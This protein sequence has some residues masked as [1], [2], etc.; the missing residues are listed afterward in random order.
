M[1]ESKGQGG[2][3]CRR[4][5]QVDQGAIGQE[6]QRIE[7][8]RLREEQHRLAEES[9]QAEQMRIDEGIRL[10]EERSEEGQRRSRA[11]R[12]REAKRLRK[13]QKRP[14]EERHQ[15]EER[16]RE[17]ERR[18]EEKR[19]ERCHEEEIRKEEW[20]REEEIRKEERRREEEERKERERVAREEREARWRKEAAV[21][22]QYLVFDS[23]LITSAAGLDIRNIVTGF[24][25]CGITIK[26]LPKD[27]KVEEIA[28]IFLQQGIS[29]AD[30][31]ITGVKEIGNF[32]KSVI[33][34]NAEYGQ[35][36]AIGLEG[37]KFRDKPLSFEI[38]DNAIPDAMGATAQSR[39]PFMTVSWR[40]LTNSIVATYMS[41][42]MAQRKVRE[43][44]GQIWRGHCITAAMN[45]C[46]PRG[47]RA[48]VMNSVKITNIPQN[49]I[50]DPEFSGFIG[51]HNVCSLK[52][53]PYDHHL[54]V[55]IHLSQQTGVQLQTY[56]ELPTDHKGEARV[57]V[58]FDDWE[59]VKLAHESIHNK[60]LGSGVMLTPN[61]RAWHPRPLQYSI[62][63]PSRQYSAQKKLWD[64]LLEKAGKEAFVQTREGGR[65]NAVFVRVL[66]DNKKA[67]GALK[68]RVEKLV[69]GEALG[70][71]YWHPSFLFS[72]TSQTFFDRTFEETGAFVRTD[73]KTRTL[74]IYGEAEK[75]GNGR[76]LI[77][78]EVRRLQGLET[79]CIIGCGSIAFFVREGV[80]RLKEL[81]GEEN[82]TL[83]LADRPC[84]ITVK[85][86]QEAI[87]H[88][89]RLIEEARTASVIGA[90]QTT[91]GEEAIC[92]LCSTKAS[93]PEQ[94]GCGHTYCAGCLRHFL[95][96]AAESKNFPLVCMG[97]DATCNKPISIPF[98]R[99]FMPEQ[100]FKHLTEVAFTCYLES[101]PQVYRYCPTADCKQVYRLQSK[102]A[103]QCPSCFSSIC[104]AC[105]EEAHEGL[106]CEE[107]IFLRDSVREERW[108]ERLGFKKCPECRRWIEKNGGCNHMTCQCGAH[109]CWRCMGVFPLSEIYDHMDSAHNGISDDELPAGVDADGVPARDFIVQQAEAL[110]QIERQRADE[111]R[112]RVRRLDA[113]RRQRQQA[114]EAEAARRQAHRRE[115]E[116]RGQQ[117][118]SGRWCVVM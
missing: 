115:L 43:L 84:R 62:K 110:A 26:N 34:T 99:R 41:T 4:G 15:E 68:V 1:H 21:V 12:R 13:E 67:T 75:V 73:F 100:A 74:K 104:P 47:L 105:D 61:L 80:G 58:Q 35:A 81:I 3:H 50:T 19:Q 69:S 31:F 109:I 25:L 53:A 98:I 55:R 49:A 51:T 33:L 108:N 44:N 106:T 107:G 63:V 9:R 10:E 88:L 71:D 86:G 14:E 39:S 23:S 20:R 54:T 5:G 11:E 97:N 52:T 37:I 30:F 72:R 42:D 85:G 46:I 95:S 117:P 94:L 76:R 70:V 57:K 8:E 77:E 59:D 27:A 48:A 91:T 93:N 87:H 89:Q 116:R 28:D 60:R 18:Q 112:Q 90:S 29:S 96:S 66:G 83:H 79:T 45:D 56:E 40:I 24:D 32:C 101:H 102:K 82:V 114:E 111:E 36:L 113:I 7:D 2:K 78:E 22:E 17:K 65:G 6:A 118:E 16:R 38:S 92:S 64:G 103:S